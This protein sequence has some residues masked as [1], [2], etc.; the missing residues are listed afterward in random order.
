MM[1]DDTRNALY[2]L[3]MGIGW[4]IVMTITFAIARALIR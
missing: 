4:V 3:S 2:V 1:D